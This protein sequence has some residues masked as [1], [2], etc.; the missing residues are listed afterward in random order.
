[1]LRILAAAWRGM[2]IRFSLLDFSVKK[3]KLRWDCIKSKTALSMEKKYHLQAVSVD[4]CRQ[5]YRRAL[6]L[7]FE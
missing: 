1:M 2:K 6:N 5:Q 7:Y 4:E 3:I